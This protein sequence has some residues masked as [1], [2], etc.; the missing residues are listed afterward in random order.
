MGVPCLSERGQ[1]QAECPRPAPH[2]CTCAHADEQ[3][4]HTHTH[5]HT[6][7]CTHTGLLWA[8]T[9]RRGPVPH[10]VS[11]AWGRG[12]PVSPAGTCP[13]AHSWSS[14]HV[15]R[16][17][18]P[19]GPCQGPRPTP[20]AGDGGRSG[21]LGTKLPNE[22]AFPRTD[23]PGRDEASTDQSPLLRWQELICDVGRDTPG[24]VAVP[25]E[26]G[27]FFRTRMSLRGAWGA[28]T[29]PAFF[30]RCPGNSW[31]QRRPLRWLFWEAGD[32]CGLG[33][34]EPGPFLWALPPPPRRASW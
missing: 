15:L 7:G 10:G 14:L 28:G 6:Q 21:F 2:G 33:G 13:G 17:P 23:A 19:N 11:K 8:T 27:P 12:R 30:A 34:K 9:A 24:P 32:K 31:E 4:T 5:T 20:T 1:P 18:P 22:Q 16:T 3:G 25:R 29:E 26:K